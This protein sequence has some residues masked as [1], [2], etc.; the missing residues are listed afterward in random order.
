MIRLV[1]LFIAT[2]LVGAVIYT[3]VQVSD[4]LNTVMADRGPTMS[5]IMRGE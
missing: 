2:A 5:E 3:L 4:R 1:V